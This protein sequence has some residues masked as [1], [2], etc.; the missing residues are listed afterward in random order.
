VEENHSCW[1]TCPA[2]PP[3]SLVAQRCAPEAAAYVRNGTWMLPT[4]A[5]AKYWPEH[6]A[7]EAQRFVRVMHTMG[8]ADG[9][10]TERPPEV[11][12][13]LRRYNVRHRRPRVRSICHKYCVILSP[14]LR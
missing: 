13:W 6:N 11:E 3:D 7:P 10:D 12:H 1:H 5:G 8:P 4:V 2:R 14:A 9:R